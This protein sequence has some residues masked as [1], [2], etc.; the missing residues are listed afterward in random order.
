M[1]FLNS[2]PEGQITTLQ[3]V[4]EKTMYNNYLIFGDNAF[5]RLANGEKKKPINMILFEAFG[6][7][8]THFESDFC[9]K[10]KQEIKEQCIGLLEQ[11]QLNKLLT[12][13]RGRGVVVTEIFIM[14]NDLKE[15]II[16]DIKNNN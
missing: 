8:F 10:F 4:F 15:R 9:E 13:D 7:L 14:I 1:E 11:K 3:L 6:Y 5:R 2:L 12:E 16:N